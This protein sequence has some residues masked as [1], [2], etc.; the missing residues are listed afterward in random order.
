MKQWLE[1]LETQQHLSQG[2]AGGSKVT[3]DAELMN[4]DLLADKH[5]QCRC[6]LALGHVLK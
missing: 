4:F 1:A 6:G 5:P 2:F 3:K